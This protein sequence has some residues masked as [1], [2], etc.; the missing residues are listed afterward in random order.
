[1]L[2]PVDL[3]SAD[4]MMQH[5]RVIRTKPLLHK[6]YEEHYHFFAEQL[7]SV[8]SGPRVEIG[9]GGGFIQEIIPETIT[10]EV[11]CV[12]HVDLV[13]SALAMP[14]KTDS[15]AAIMMINVFHH[16]QD[17]AQFLREVSRCLVPGGKVLMIEPANTL[18]SRF[19]YSNFHHEPFDPA[20]QQWQLPPGGRMTTANDA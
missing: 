3:D 18:W 15:L 1:M 12:P 10:S 9:S 19:V 11:I 7:R 20:Q 8:P 17:A 4:A 14:F 5:R 13:F 16:L 2:A 6:I